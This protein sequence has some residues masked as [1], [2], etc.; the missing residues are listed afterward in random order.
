MISFIASLFNPAIDVDE[1]GFYTQAIGG[2]F[3]VHRGTQVEY[4]IP[5]EYRDFMIIK[6]PLLEEVA[7]VY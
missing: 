7:Y 4:F 3:E 5:K 2:Y 1:I 6:Y